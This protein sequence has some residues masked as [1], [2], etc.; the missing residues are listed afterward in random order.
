MCNPKPKDFS[1]FNPIIPD[2]E[3]WLKT[4]KEKIEILLLKIIKNE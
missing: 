4:N 1:P 3:N 2:L